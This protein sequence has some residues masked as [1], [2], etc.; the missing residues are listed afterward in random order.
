MPP[1][2]IGS[3]GIATTLTSKPIKA[4][5]PR[6]GS[7]VNPMSGPSN[8][9]GPQAIRPT[10]PTQ[11]FDPAYLQNLATAIGGLFSRP[12]GNLSFNPLGDLSGISQKTGFG[13]APVPGIP[14][15]M[16]QDALNGLGFGGSLTTPQ[17]VQ[18]QQP[19]SPIKPQPPR[20]PGRGPRQE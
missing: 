8:T 7:P 5:P 19:T 1:L 3:P 11:G 9:L 2:Y 18:P 13:N 20:I 4:M 17:Q 15:T 14:G 16:L 10:G 6:A 12:Q